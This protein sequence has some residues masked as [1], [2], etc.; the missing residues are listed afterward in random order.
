MS[1]DIGKGGGGSGNN[2]VASGVVLVDAD[3]SPFRK[4]MAGLPSI[5]KKSAQDATKT[6]QAQIDRLKMQVEVLQSSLKSGQK[7]L[8]QVSQLMQLC[9]IP[10]LSDVRTASR[11]EALLRRIGGGAK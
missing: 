4:S 9:A 11:I 8:T 10:A 2:V 5:A 3:I 1:T 6:L 7:P